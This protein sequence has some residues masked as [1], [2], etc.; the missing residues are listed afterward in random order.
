MHRHVIG[1][2][3]AAGLIVVAGATAIGAQHRPIRLGVL[4]AATLSAQDPKLP[5][6]G[7]FHSYRL[8]ARR[9]DRF[10]ITMSSAALRRE[11]TVSVVRTIGGL[12]E[13]VANASVH[14]SESDARLQFD[15]PETGTY[16]VVTQAFSFG[17]ELYGPYQLK[18]DALQPATAA[19]ASVG[20]AARAVPHR[21]ILVGVPI[22]DSLTSRDLKISPRLGGVTSGAFHTYRLEARRG[23]RFVVAMQSSDVNA[24]VWVAKT[25]GGLTQAVSSSGMNVASTASL[26]FSAPEAG[27]Y[28][29]VAQSRERD[30]V[31]AYVL[32]VDAVPAAPPAAD[33]ALVLGQVREGMLVVN[34]PWTEDGVP[35]QPYTYSGHGERVNFSMNSDAFDPCMLIYRVD[36][37]G[38]IEK[39]DSAE[40]NQSS[41]FNPD[42]QYHIYARAQDPSRVG[43]F[44]IVV[45]EVPVRPIAARTIAVGQTA[46]GTITATD[47]ETDEEQYFHQYS[48][49]LP[50]GVRFRIVV[51]SPDFDA[52][53][54]LGVGV[55]AV[56]SRIDGNDNGPGGTDSQLDVRLRRESTYLIRVHGREP[57]KI[58]TYQLS[59]ERLP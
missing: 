50:A 42:G 35:H 20:T 54:T 26:R 48:V 27:T 15:A 14:D 24:H 2:V 59:V 29:V 19:A 40:C 18:V 25:T 17:R 5:S 45:K 44:S 47:P 37:T 46:V 41:A 55:G 13:E 32:Q 39:D 57:R 11:Q 1:R 16:L 28:L 4:M 34:S 22:A 31:G 56:H 30:G 58:G 21:P 36:S 7:A 8:D 53:V 6:S 49:A 9:G 10:V 23:D 43:A 51:K 12:T 52:F 3:L 33:N 38:A